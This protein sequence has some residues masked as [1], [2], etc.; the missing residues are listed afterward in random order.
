MV[1]LANKYQIHI[2]VYDILAQHGLLIQMP[3]WT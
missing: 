1:G 3:V 2:S